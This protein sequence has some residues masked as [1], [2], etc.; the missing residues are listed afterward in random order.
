M[1]LYCLMHFRSIHFFFF[2]LKKRHW[3]VND[4]M[5]EDSF[6]KASSWWKWKLF[7]SQ[8]VYLDVYY[9]FL[10]S[11]RQTCKWMYL[12]H[13]R[14]MFQWG[15]SWIF[16]ASCF[17]GLNYLIMV[18]WLDV[19]IAYANVLGYTIIFLKKKKQ[20]TVQVTQ[21]TTSEWWGRVRFWKVF[22]PPVGYFLLKSW[23]NT[24]KERSQWESN[25]LLQ[26]NLM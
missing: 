9:F 7:T 22:I 12:L 16:S 2:F 8:A 11:L 25:D 19:L 23:E 6:I 26:W 17:S 15:E 10:A 18:N 14:V 13:H 24:G 3:E 5:R 21:K 4:K 20:K 1:H